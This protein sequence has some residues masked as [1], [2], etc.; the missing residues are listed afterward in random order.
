MK[1]TEKSN[2]FCTAHLVYSYDTGVFVYTPS[3]TDMFGSHFDSRPLW[4][5]FSDD[6]IGS[7]SSASLFRDT[8]LSIG[9]DDEDRD[10]V[11]RELNVKT[12]DD[13]YRCV[14]AV[15]IK[16]P[17]DKK[18]IVTFSHNDDISI[19]HKD[20]LSG[21]LTR[22]I[23]TREL[24]DIISRKPE[25]ELRDYIVVYLD[26]LRFKMVNDIFGTEKGNELLKYVADIISDT[27]SDTGLGCR[28][29]SDRFLFY[30]KCSSEKRNQFISGLL[31]RI[32]DFNLSFEV[33]CNAGIYDIQDKTVSAAGAVDRAIIAQKSIKGSYTSRYA[34]YTED[35]RKNLA[36]EQ[37]ISGL[38][39]TALEEEQFIVYYQPQYNHSTGMLVGA[40]ALVRWLHPDRGLIPPNVFISI[41]EK[42]GFITQLD[43]YVFEKACIFLRKCID[44]NFHLVPVSVNLTRY[45]IFSPGFIDRL[46]S[47]RRKYDIPSKYIR[48]EITESAALGNS[49]YINDAVKKLHSYGFVVEMD[50]FGSGYS[51]L[52][53]L[54][55]IEFDIIKL[56]MKFLEKHTLDNARGVTILS[57]VVRMINWLSLPV[58][59]EGVETLQQADYLGSIGCDYIQGY[60]YSKPLPEADYEKLVSGNSVGIDKTM[61]DKISQDV[62]TTITWS[63]DTLQTLI[64][65]RYAG[66]AAVFEYT[67]DGTAEILRVN[68]KY[69]QEI[70]MNLTEKDL[71]RSDPMAV[72]DEENRKIFTDTIELAIRTGKEQE[73]VTWRTLRSECCGEEYICLRSTIQLIGT[74]CDRYL[75]HSTVKNITADMLKIETAEKNISSFRKAFE[76]INVYMW[77]YSILTKEMKP[78]YRCMRDLGLPPVVRNYPEPAFEA[79]IFPEDYREMYYDWMKQLENGAEKL[80][81][82]IPLTADRIPFVV[83][84]TTEFDET[85]RPVKAYG[86]AAMVADT[87]KV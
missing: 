57:S 53:I 54:K 13:Q 1:N 39:K 58:I 18:V 23:F 3:M 62:S 66:C 21:L 42:N 24:N 70:S 38:M 77:E 30:A 63:N 19:R 28:I 40:E 55:D 14:L 32:S 25:N 49:E 50:D 60:Y 48:V 45:D 87:G 83:R 80:E 64:F 11:F 5:I 7:Q 44:M 10:I 61:T 51:S 43:M 37:E 65:S 81:G 15:F 78:C 74:S 8:L 73:C 76:Q 84:Y 31:N 46:E 29:E 12:A 26:I 20:T 75:F 56:D 79:G 35:L 72:F 47:V 9:T 69:L 86:S 27:V 85:G 36:L 52:N 17:C 2:L 67:K 71:I 16:K 34:F 6:N 4:Q 22:E 33:M 82:I 68:K 59:A 41:F